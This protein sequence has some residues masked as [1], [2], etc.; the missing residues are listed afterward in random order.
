MLKKDGFRWG[1]KVEVAFEHLKKAKSE[2]LVLRLSDFSKTFVVETDA[3]DNG[4]GGVLMQEGRSIAF[5]SQALAPRHEGLSI[6][7]KE[8]VVVLLAVEK[9]T[10]YLEK[11][12]F[13]I[14]TNHQSLK[15][16]LQ[17]RLHTQLQKNGMVKW[18]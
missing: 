18:T 13:V 12:Q 2:V 9:W 17:Q 1:P 6:Y 7:E 3:C 15:Y 4:V 11:C 5:L 14:K 8:F 16:L 10:H